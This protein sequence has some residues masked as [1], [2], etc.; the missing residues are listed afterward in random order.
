[1]ELSKNVPREPLTHLVNTVWEAYRVAWYSPRRSDP[2]RLAAIWLPAGVEPD[3][4]AAKAEVDRIVTLSLADQMTTLAEKCGMGH[5][6]ARFAAAGWRPNTYTFQGIYKSIKVLQRAI[7]QRSLDLDRLMRLETEE[8]TAWY[9]CELGKFT[10]K[11]LTAVDDLASWD[12]V[13]EAAGFTAACRC[14]W[15]LPTQ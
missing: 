4:K 5:L 13:R 6:P 7:S 9:S 12:T 11:A 14:R 10:G 1:M 8:G 2:P 15:P 3:W